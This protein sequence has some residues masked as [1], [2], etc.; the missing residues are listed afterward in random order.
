MQSLLVDK[1]KAIPTR[2]M[3]IC[4]LGEKK[5][6]FHALSEQY[7]SAV[8]LAESPNS[9]F[10]SIFSSRVKYNLNEIKT[11]AQDDNWRFQVQLETVLEMLRK[12]KT[13]KSLGNDGNDDLCPLKA[14]HEILAGPLDRIFSL[15]VSTCTFPTEW[16][17]ALIAPIP[18]KRNPLPSDFRPISLLTIPSKC[19]KTASSYRKGKACLTLR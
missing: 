1:L 7:N 13:N 8:D 16:K 2:H 15:S 5:E 12:L 17:T 4:S 14:A 9:S 6:N 18:K 11:L 3:E 10:S 19:S